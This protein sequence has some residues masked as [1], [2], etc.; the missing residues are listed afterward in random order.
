MAFLLSRIGL[1]RPRSEMIKIKSKIKSDEWALNKIKSK[2]IKMNRRAVIS[3]WHSDPA[4]C[5]ARGRNLR[6][7]QSH[8]YL[9]ESSDHE[10]VWYKLYMAIIYV[11]MY[12][13]TSK[14]I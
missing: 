10:L 5:N 1:V 14:L 2:Q 12:V 4:I 11:G 8:I 7:S 9:V 3:A 13:Y 6:H